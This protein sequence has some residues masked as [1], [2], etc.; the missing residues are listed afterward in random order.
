MR[1]HRQRIKVWRRTCEYCYCQKTLTIT[2]ALSLQSGR[3]RAAMKAPC[4]PVICCACIRVLQ[5]TI[6]GKWRSCQRMHQSLEDIRKSLPMCKV[7]AFMGSLSLSQ[8]HTGCSG[9]PKQKPRGGSIL[10]PAP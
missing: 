4:L 5:K 1:L 10:Q 6:G 8:V 2:V 9:C 3:V 7:K